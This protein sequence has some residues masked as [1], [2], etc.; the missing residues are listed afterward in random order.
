MVHSFPALF[1]KQAGLMVFSN[2]GPPPSL[3]DLTP[4]IAPRPALLIWAPNGGNAET[5]NPTYQ[6][7]IGPSAEIWE[8][9]DAMHI[10]GIKQHP[11]EYERRV[12]GF[13]DRALLGTQRPKHCRRIDGLP[14]SRQGRAYDPTNSVAYRQRRRCERGCRETGEVGARRDPPRLQATRS[15]RLR[16]KVDRLARRIAVPGRLRRRLVG[17]RVRDW[18]TDCEGPCAIKLGGRV[19][20]R[21]LRLPRN[22]LVSP[23]LPAGARPTRSRDACPRG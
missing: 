16:R 3:V 22:V 6:R 21:G 8:I 14:V 19:R 7:L 5:M 11:E 17:L 1:T 2:Q 18:R 4:R 20:F 10:K 23:P 13:F 12:V 15:R 9:D